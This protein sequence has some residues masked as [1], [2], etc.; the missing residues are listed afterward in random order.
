MHQ[1]DAAMEGELQPLIDALTTADR[2]K[3]L[4]DSVDSAGAD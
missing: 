4:E 1:L 2:A 3:R